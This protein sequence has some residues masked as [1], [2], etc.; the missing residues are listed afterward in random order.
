MAECTMCDICGQVIRDDDAGSR[1][2]KIKENK[3]YI[4]RRYNAYSSY[5]EEY[6]GWER[7]DCH[8]ECVEKLLKART[9]TEAKRNGS[10]RD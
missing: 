5:C 8:A 1:Q 9:D 6:R 4:V 7:I 3:R 2:F 10:S